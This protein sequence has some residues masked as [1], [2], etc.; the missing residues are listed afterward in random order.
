MLDSMTPKTR[1]ITS[2]PARRWASVSAS[3]YTNAQPT[4]DATTSRQDHDRGRPKADRGDG[5]REEGARA[6]VD[7]G[8]ALAAHQ[9]A[10]HAGA[11]DRA[12]P[13]HGG[14]VP[15]RALVAAEQVDGDHRQEDVERTQ[16]RDRAAED[17]H[18]GEEAPIADDRPQ[19]GT[20]LAEQPLT[21]RDRHGH[22]QRASRSGQRQDGEERREGQQRQGRVHRFR[23]AEA[24]KQP[25][26]ERAEQ[27]AEALDGPGRGVR[28]GQRLGRL[29]HLRQERCVGRPD[30]RDACRREHRHH[31]S[32]ERRRDRQGDGG[33]GH[34]KRQDRVGAGQDLGPRASI[35]EHGRRRGHHDR[36]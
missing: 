28:H 6:H 32:D 3:T 27:R 33:A 11:K 16:E 26:E 25:G 12:E 2:S 23:T 21:A 19:A 17:R 5:R 9:E 24:D 35:A 10:R 31:V 14:Q 13:C 34:R 36:G 7:R 18:D 15:D 29:R 4:P 30:E 20:K 1:L 22:D 8:K